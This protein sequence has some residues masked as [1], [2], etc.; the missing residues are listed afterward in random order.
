MRVAYVADEKVI[1]ELSRFAAVL[2]AAVTGP[3]DP[4]DMEN[5]EQNKQITRAERRKILFAFSEVSRLI[6]QDLISQP[7]DTEILKSIIE[8]FSK[9]GEIA[10]TTAD[11]TPISSPTNA[12][13]GQTNFAS[14]T[15]I[16]PSE[17]IKIP[18]GKMTPT[19][20]LEQCKEPGEREFF[21]AF[22][23]L[24]ETNKFIPLWTQKGFSIEKTVRF[25]PSEQIFPKWRSYIERPTLSKRREKV[26]AALVVA[27][28]N[29]QFTEKPD[30]RFEWE[31]M[32]NAT[33]EGFLEVV[34]A[35]LR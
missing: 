24:L 10:D 23:P 3:N 22:L 25:H 19:Q 28:V 21:A 15:A 11:G 32:K 9:A 13:D 2:R 16:I 5:D 1:S 18:A 14:K 20:F 7:V 31:Q 27:G 26:E 17:S 33:P 29:I 4:E 30:L 34:K 12:G 6:R 35:V 8:D